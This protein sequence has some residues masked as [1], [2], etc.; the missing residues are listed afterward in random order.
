MAAE[1]SFLISGDGG[2]TPAVFVLL[3]KAAQI[4]AKAAQNR[5]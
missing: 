2:L 3:D 4:R 1:V 5:G